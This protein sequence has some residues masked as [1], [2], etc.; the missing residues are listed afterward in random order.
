M[1]WK[2][3]VFYLLDKGTSGRLRHG[4]AVYQYNMGVFSAIVNK[5]EYNNSNQCGLRPL[6]NLL[7]LQIFTPI[8]ELNLLFLL[9]LV[10]LS[11]KSRI[12]YFPM[13][14]YFIMM[15]QVFIFIFLFRETYKL[16]YFFQ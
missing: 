8:V 4:G 5:V 9:F 13:A 2:I 16:I 1:W 14:N 7:F 3:L 15:E 10:L 12:S 6:S 11:S